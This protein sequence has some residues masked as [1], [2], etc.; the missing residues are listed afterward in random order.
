[1]CANADINNE[2]DSTQPPQSDEAISQFQQDTVSLRDQ[3]Y[4]VVGTDVPIS[5]WKK[6]L[7]R[8]MRAHLLI[9]CHLLKQLQMWGTLGGIDEQNI[10]TCHAIRNK[11][12]RQFGATH[13]NELQKKML[14]EH[15]FQTSPFLHCAKDHV[16]KETKSKRKKNTNSGV[17]NS[18]RLEEVTDVSHVVNH[19]VDNNVVLGHCRLASMTKRLSTKN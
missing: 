5:G 15:L 2:N 19:L 12:L 14:S 17:Q 4:K 6:T 10:E 1:M 9:G 11:L 18:R 8:S 7:T 13:G 3:I 16:K